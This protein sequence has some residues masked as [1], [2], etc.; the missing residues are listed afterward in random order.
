MEQV[1]FWTAFFKAKSQFIAPEKT[2]VNAFANNHKY[3]KLEALIEPVYEALQ[4][5]GIE[6]I[7]EDVNC[8]EEAGARITMFHLPSGQSYTQ[9]CLVDK[10][11]RTAQGTASCYTYAKRYLITSLFTIGDMKSDD[12]GHEASQPASEPMAKPAEI[13]LIKK[14]L[15][16]LKVS[17]KKALESV[18]ALS[19]K[20]TQ[21]QANQIQMRIK[22]LKAS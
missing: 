7:F 16:V 21:S 19:W 8:P 12:D 22:E 10:E 15:A 9:E 20:L 4:S 3:F 6:F 5:N 1:H 13:D 2:G 18:S 14:D 11:R 17:Q